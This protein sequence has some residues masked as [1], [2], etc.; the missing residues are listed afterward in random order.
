M[1]EDLKL[2]LED[3]E[4]QLSTMEEVLIDIT[5]LPSL[6]EVTREQI[7]AVFRAMHT[8]KGNAGMFGLDEIVHFTHRAESL[9]DKVR[10]GEIKLTQELVDL[11]LRINDHVRMLVELTVNDEEMDDDQKAQHKELLEI[12]E[13]YLKGEQETKEKEV[14]ESE[15]VEEEV[16]DGSY[17]IEIELYENFFEINEDIFAIFKLLDVIGTIKDFEEDLSKLPHIKAIDPKKA[18]LSFKFKYESEE[19]LEEIADNFKPLKGGAQVIIKKGGKVLFK[20]DEEEKEEKPKEQ[21][22]EKPQEQSQ[23]QSQ[24]KLQEKPQEKKPPKKKKEKK[25]YT[26]RV[27]SEKVDMLMNKIS[28]MVILNA[29]LIQYAMDKNDFEL[30]ENVLKMSDL[31]E[32]VRDGI[33]NIRMVQVG[34]SFA[35]FRRIVLE[36]AKKLG[37]EVHFEIIG[38]DTELDKSMIEKITDPLIHILRNSVDH[39][40]EPPEERIKLGKPPKGNIIL[41]AYPDSGMIVIEIIDDGRGIDKNK[42]LQKAIEKGIIPP[43]ANL[44]DKEIFNLIFAPGIS[45]ASEVSDISGRGVGMDVVKKNIDSLRG[46][47]EIESEPGK[48]TKITIRLPLTLAIIDGFLVQVANVKYVIPLEMIKECIELTSDQKEKV[49]KQGYI[50]LRKKILPVLDMKEFFDVKNNNSLRENI[51]IV[52]YGDK[53]VGLLVDEFYGEFQTVIKPLGELFEKVQGISGGTI[54]GSGEVGLIFDIPR[55]VEYRIALEHKKGEQDG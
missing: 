16:D 43:N 7:N 12:I 55:L 14:I 19:K 52:K 53:E 1:N 32:K 47:I 37:K 4:E 40:I 49:Q 31:I 42:V 25:S 13:R 10:N 17:L 22:Q 50:A 6:E 36:T 44:S 39:G 38:E 45:T 18:Y 23:E 41:K 54:L 35:K 2:F 51:V 29:R 9:L 11:F 46:S 3:S 15:V 34:D 33:M 28:E 8:I 27:N 30:E 20:L 21:S 5:E 24:E 26:L 48:G